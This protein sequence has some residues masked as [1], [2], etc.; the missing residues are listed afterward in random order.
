MHSL[1][2]RQLKKTGLAD[3]ASE[4]TRDAWL[5]LLDRVNQSY[6]EA[7]QDRYLLE[8]SLSIS[9]REMQALS[10]NLSAE[11]D[12]LTAILHS[13]GD[14]LCALDPMGRLL[15][16]N[17]Q[18]EQLLG[19]EEHELVGRDLLATVG[20]SC[21]TDTPGAQA[22]SLSVLVGAGQTYRNEDD[23]FACK[24]GTQLPVSYVVTPLTTQGCLSGA[25]VVFRDMT[26]RKQQLAAQTQLVRRESLLRLARR[27]ALESDPEQVLTDLLDEAVAVLGGHDGTLTRWDAANRVLVPVRNRVPTAN[28][29]TVMKVGA[30]VSGRA[31]EQRA[32][33]ILNDYQQES[34]SETP[35]GKA[36]VRAAV[37]VPLLHEGRLIGAL[38]V[39]TY[40]PAR[41]FTD[42]DAEV[43]ELLAGLASASL[44]SLERTFELAE[45]NRDLRQARDEAQRQALHDGLTDL[46]NRTLLHDRLSQAILSAR[47]GNTPLTLLLID[48]DRFKEIN[49]TFGHHYGDLLLQQIGPRLRRVLR[50]SDTVARLGGDEFGIV[51]PTTNAEAALAVA[52]QLLRRLEAP[53]EVDG[54]TVEIGAS[55]GIASYPTDGN[56]AATLLRLADVAMYVAKRGEHGIVV[57]APEH[58]HYSAERLALGGELRGAIERNQLLLH[59]QPKLDLRDGTLVGVEALVRWQHPLRGFLPPS[60]FIPLAE[61][62]GLI[63]PLTRWVLDAALRQH[64]AWLAM[65]LEVPVAVNLSR[66]TLHDPQ[67]PE[68]VAQ[69]LA[70][71]DVPPAALVL[72]IT[73]SSL[74]ADPQRA[75][76]HLTQLRTLGVRISIDDFGTGFSSL[77]SL[78]ALPLDELKID[79]SFV[80]AMATDASARAIV[81]A[82]IDLADA[83]NLRVVAE[84][85]EDRATWDVLA[86]LG[87]E[88]AQGYF[89]SRPVAA[90]E[91]EAWIAQVVPTWLAAPA[92]SCFEDALQERIRGRGARLTAEEEFI[93][94]KQAE[95]ALRASEERN[96][97]ALQA[98]GMGTWDWDVI[99]DVHTWSAETEVLFGFAPGT[100]D[101]TFAAFRRAVNPNDWPAFEIEELA[102]QAERR[103][104]VTS[105]RTVWSDG[106]VHWMESKGRS[107]YAPDGTLVRMTGTC[108]D[109][110]E[111]KRAEEALRASEERLQK[112]YQDLPLPTYS[113]CQAGDDFVLEAYNDAAEAATEGHVGEWLGSRASKRYKDQPEILAE[114]HACLTEQRTR[115][116]E[117]RSY[118]NVGQVGRLAITCVFV[119]P[120]S[121]MLHTHDGADAMHAEQ[122]VLVA[123]TC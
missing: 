121:V 103:D 27:F 1:L 75:F 56:D 107:L 96:R 108:M 57:Y 42:E 32:P 52:Q 112:Q 9:S 8:R 123:R 119:P 49:D 13:L 67:L 58:D 120:Q 110:T 22:A 115:R 21:A 82:I 99:N 101:G 114:L 86:G 50:D 43:L 72:E 44:A 73:E 51:L 10:V 20:A 88:V 16:I 74:M 53:F 109:I 87:C 14:G 102:A 29:Y 89:L 78:K 104:S 47:R 94:R 15:L 81:R 3:V 24:D 76:E 60:E 77:A 61:Q 91:L 68:M 2:A 83:L 31:I 40:D 55:I 18:G 45:A 66:R 38:S 41:K 48:L 63:H 62:T 105:Y 70:R 113:W 12:R 84:G 85:V 19:W 37:A 54:Q 98:A 26:M 93:A 111:R 118:G 64:Q 11:R 106:G 35:A 117:T 25:V 33:V 80:Q 122:S 59:F 39:N 90:A 46:P 65:G 6:I 28:E 92:D 23:S 71:W 116:R 5:A 79:Q 4:P 30:G 34:G 97:L 95:A 100:F 17:P 7:D 36:G 69:L